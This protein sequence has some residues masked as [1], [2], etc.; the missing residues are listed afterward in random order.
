MKGRWRLLAVA[1]SVGLVALALSAAWLATYGAAANTKTI[2]I[3]CKATSYVYP[4]IEQEFGTETTYTVGNQTYSSFTVT[5][6]SSP[7]V[8]EAGVSSYLT[9]TNQTGSSGSVVISTSPS[10]GGS[11]C[12]PSGCWTVITCTYLG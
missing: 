1:A 7:T 8:T 10:D 9:T 12:E 6:V 2:T 11:A 3:T 5:S 4:D